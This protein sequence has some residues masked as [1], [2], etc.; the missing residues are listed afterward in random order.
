MKK[1]KNTRGKN[2]DEENLHAAMSV[3]I[4]R[5]KGANLAIKTTLFNKHYMKVMS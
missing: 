1:K 2:Q 3:H 5:S 4:S